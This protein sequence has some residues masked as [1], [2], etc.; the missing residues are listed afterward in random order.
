[1]HPIK[2]IFIGTPTFALPAFE[3]LIKDSFFDMVGVVTQPDKPVGRKQTLT[4]PPIKILAEQNNI[5]VW[6]PKKIKEITGE[7]K[8]LNPDLIVV[9][10]YAQIIP[11][12]ILNIP[13]YGCVNVH[14]SLLPK[15]RGASCIQAAILNGDCETGIT[16]MKMD[17]GLDTGDILAQKNIPIQNDDTAASLYDKLSLLGGEILTSILEKYIAGEIQ[18]KK[19]DDARASYVG[20]LKKEDGKINWNKN[21]TEIER[22]AR[23]MNN[24][25]RAWSQFIPPPLQGGVGGG[26]QLS[27]KIL[28]VESEILLINKYKVG[29][30]FLE[31]KKLAVQC[32][33]DALIIKK[34]QLEGKKEMDA[35]DFI[36][37]HQD[38]IGKVLN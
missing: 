1:M 29:E 14:G 23:A 6:Q 26:H 33:K 37:G 36:R 15:Y 20:L 22:F 11:E 16:I 21:A 12:E 8:K 38:F 34:L 9:A 4:P 35:Q 24:W 13:K 18:P 31:D 25:P 30:I 7:I 2:V 28:E 10:A 5:L 32:G 3:S 27:I 17:K 19:Q